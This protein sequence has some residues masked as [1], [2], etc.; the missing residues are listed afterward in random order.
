MGLKGWAATATAGL[1]F[2]AA[3]PSSGDTR[4]GPCFPSRSTTLLENTR[5]RVYKYPDSNPERGFSIYGCAFSTQAQASIDAPDQVFAFLPPAMSLDGATLGFAFTVCGGEGAE[6]VPGDRCSTT[7][8]V[9]DL[10]S[11]KEWALAAGARPVVKVGS[12]RAS[13][14][15]AVAWIACPEHQHN[16]NGHYAN[17]SP[18]CVSPGD[19]DSVYLVHPGSR[20]RVL[21]DRGT[22]IDP[23]SL[24]RSGTRVYWRN[25]AKRRS[26]LLR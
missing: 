15:G 24:E 4:H 6:P 23:S 25:G 22:R 8:D 13:R 7:V 12:L 5:A 14:Q 19:R 26:A 10:E 3:A 9:L 18:N 17:R 2:F 11:Q 1:A 16:S 21:L 20:T